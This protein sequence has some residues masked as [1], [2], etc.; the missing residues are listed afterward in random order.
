MAGI[1]FL[2]LTR[3]INE[4]LLDTEL[5]EWFIKTPIGDMTTSAW[6][7]RDKNSPLGSIVYQK[8]SSVEEVEDFADLFLKYIK[9][10]ERYFWIRESDPRVQMEGFKKLNGHHLN[11]SLRDNIALWAAH[12]IQTN[13]NDEIIYGVKRGEEMLA[14]VLSVNPNYSGKEMEELFIRILREKFKDII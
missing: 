9:E 11:A 4:L 2:D 10:C 12:G 3:T 5:K 7:L 14:K 6:R 13:N 1:H 8:F